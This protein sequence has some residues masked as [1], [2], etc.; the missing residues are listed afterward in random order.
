MQPHMPSNCNELL[1]ADSPL[2]G[3][4]NIAVVVLDGLGDSI[5]ALPALRFLIKAC[6]QSK[7]T[8]IASKLGAPVFADITEVAIF[9][10]KEIGFKNK[11]TSTLKQGKFQA[12]L[13]FTEKGFALSSVFRSGAP[14]RCGFFPGLSQ[15]L[16]SLSLLWQ[17]NYRVPFS[18][19][20]RQDAHLHQTARFFL[21]LEKLGVKVPAEA[22][23]PDLTFNFTQQEL[24]EGHKAYIETLELNQ[25]A[26]DSCNLN[27]IKSCALQLMPRWNP[28]ILGIIDKQ[29]LISAP[30]VSQTSHENR[31]NY[32][33]YWPLL[34][35]VAKLYEKLL[36]DKFRPIITC[37]PGDRLWADR[38]AAD[39]AVYLSQKN[40]YA[41]ERQ[42]IKV[43]IFSCADL[44]L[45]AAFLKNCRFMI[46]P[47]G[48]S[49]HTAAAV[50]LP[51]VVFFPAENFER[52]T[53]RWKPWR[54]SCQLVAR[55][56]KNQD[57]EK[58][59]NTLYEACKKIC[60]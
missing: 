53:T 1:K 51:S 10:P 23:Y 25:T 8:V 26:P 37:A 45:F 31:D 39:L 3:A 36:D 22:D 2:I 20:P 17:I 42:Q 43:P 16:K 44:R 47:D 12:V 54:N 6:P 19:D 57:D 21:L 34:Q 11:L 49:A 30:P 35:P 5:L 4:H 46:S 40:K 55:Q 38:F 32:S 27:D 50:G 24:K 28:N 58:F 41:Q 9:D 33:P 56:E 13:S 52:N 60:P 48:G 29:N 18:N 14:V 15:P 59:S 7:I